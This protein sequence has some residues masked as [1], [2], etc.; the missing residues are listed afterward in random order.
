[1]TSISLF[2]VTIL[3]AAS[4][5]FCVGNMESHSCD[6]RVLWQKTERICFIVLIKGVNILPEKPLVKA[7]KERSWLMHL[8]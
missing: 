7:L 6:L 1:M 5:V 2:E 4:L 8:V 3:I